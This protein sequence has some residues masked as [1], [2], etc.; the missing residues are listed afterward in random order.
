MFDYD[1]MREVLT[2]ADILIGH[3]IIC[4]DIPVIERLLS[5]TIKAR[6]IDTLGL[7]WYLNHTNSLHG[8][9]FYGKIYKRPKPKIDDW[10]NL[11]PEEYAHRCE[12]DVWINAKLW[13][14]LRTK[15]LQLYESKSEADRLIEYIS[16][17]MDCLRE[18]EQSKW[19]LDIERAKSNIISL[20]EQEREK[21]ETLRKLMPP[22]PLIAKRVRPA[23]PFK[24]DG[25]LSV[26]GAK[27][28][29]LLRDEGLPDDFDG[30]IEVVVGHEEPNPGSHDQIK[31]WLKSLGWKPETFKF[32][33][34]RKIP[35]VRVEV[36]GNKE[37][38]PSVIKLAE[39]EPAI[40]VLEGL[41]VV[42]HRLGIFRGYIECEKDGYLVAGAHGFTNTLR[43]K[44]RKPLVNLPGVSKAYGEEIRG[45]LIAEE[46]ELLCG[47]DMVSLE[48]TT[49]RH[50]MYDYDPD[51]VNQMSVEGFDPHL[52]LALHGGAVTQQ[53]VDDWINKVEGAKNLKP[54]R[55]Q[56]K[57]ANYA[58]IYGVG[59]AKLARDL[60]ISKSE[61]QAL[62]DA[63]WA[64]N[65]AVKALV[66]DLEIKHL[67]GEM[68]L[69][70]PVSKFYYSLRFKKDAFSTLNQS[71]G[72]FCFDSWIRQW[73][74]V[75]PQLIAQFHDEI[76]SG[77]PSGKED[78]YSKILRH[79]L[80]QVNA[81]LNLNIKLDID[82]QYGKNYAEI[83]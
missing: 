13:F 25:T 10:S 37:L 2:N 82:I 32:D 29:K 11:T 52:D 53:E 83:H 9:E 70:N 77:I 73:R 5:I 16:F 71:T 63:Y 55:T 51:Y 8:L 57:T 28:F 75:R 39:K 66:D 17:K 62:I 61:A 78:A 54:L 68:W 81:E 43:F 46:G 67:N 7:S 69:F 15:L 21:I 30:V 12:E 65:W 48:D 36:D 47:S 26:T 41:T 19:K 31:S 1:E 6:R 14:Q 40:L 27:W 22:K 33:G 59:A 35:Q 42:Q 23:K 45:S 58:C 4:Y 64:R 49:K 18:Q 60:G 24:K 3:N 50:Y 44:H 56:F 80:E 79:A 38:C 74:K 20:E 34:D 72:V 76:I